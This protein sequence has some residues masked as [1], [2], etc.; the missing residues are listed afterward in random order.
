MNWVALLA[1][2]RLSYYKV[3]LASQAIY[4]DGTRV[5]H[6]LSY[7][8]RTVP[9]TREPYTAFALAHVYLNPELLATISHGRSIQ[10]QLHDGRGI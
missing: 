2:Q 3:I 6:S 1:T 4:I 5:V 7:S 8:R 9:L 10:G